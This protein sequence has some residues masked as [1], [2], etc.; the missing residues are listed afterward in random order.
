MNCDNFKNKIDAFVD[1]EL[2]PVEHEQ[3]KEHVEQCPNCSLLYNSYTEMLLGLQD[4]GTIEYTV[5]EELHNKII[6]S[7]KQSKNVYVP[8]K[9]NTPTSRKKYTL[10]AGLLGLFIATGSYQTYQFLQH[11]I[12]EEQPLITITPETPEPKLEPNHPEVNDSSVEITQT[13]EATLQ[14][15]QA[16]QSP[17]TPVSNENINTNE[18]VTPVPNTSV[19]QEEKPVQDVSSV[20]QVSQ[21]E[22]ASLA[23]KATT[24]G[25]APIADLEINFNDTDN[26]ENYFNYIST[27]KDLNILNIE[28]SG[29]EYY[30]EANTSDLNNFID[31]VQQYKNTDGM[32]SEITISILNELVNS[33]NGFSFILK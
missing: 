6:D 31:Y 27:Y 10:V 8:K 21:P 17:D 18:P 13:D 11:D 26:L 29:S 1:C 28:N 22:Q 30:I 16:T 2:T 32:Q 33:N 12:V 19:I 7:V 24:F 4:L 23:P 20:Q 9:S 14:L 3:F 5:S 15:P 25:L